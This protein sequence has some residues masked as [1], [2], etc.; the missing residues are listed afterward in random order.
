MGVGSVGSWLVR[1]SASASIVASIYVLI[2]LFLGILKDRGNVTRFLPLSC[3]HIS[4]LACG[5]IF[6]AGTVISDSL[7]VAQ[8]GSIQFFYLASVLWT[9]AIAVRLYRVLVM[10]MTSKRYDL[11]GLFL[12][13]CW[14]VPLVTVIAGR[15]TNSFGRLDDEAKK[16]CWVRTEGQQ[17]AFLYGPMSCLVVINAIIFWVSRHKTKQ[18]HLPGMSASDQSLFLAY[19]AVVVLSNIWSVTYAFAKLAGAPSSHISWLAICD[20]FFS[21]LQGFLHALV[22]V[23]YLRNP[24]SKTSSSY[25]RLSLQRSEANLV[26]AQPLATKT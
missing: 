26:L 14:G 15:T 8:A 16:W 25:L 22:Y 24:P 7:C 17:F 13:V 1:V 19:L 11:N 5:T 12:L 23:Y 10:R 9:T 18:Q 21:P 20:E 2:M 6:L 3:L 4:E